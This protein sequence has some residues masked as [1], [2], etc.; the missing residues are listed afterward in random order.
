[1]STSTFAKAKAAFIDRDG[2]INE[3]RNYV[4]RIEE[5]VLLPGVFQGLT[6]LRNAGYLLIV[7][8]NQ[9]GIARGYYDK[10]AMENIHDHLRSLLAQKGVV[11]DAI[12]FCPHHP[13]GNV[14]TL[15][16]ECECRKP[17]PGM[18]F[19]A[20]KDFDLD[21]TASILIGDKISDVQA[22]R[23]AGVGRTVIVKSGHNLEPSA[24]LEADVIAADLFAAARL[25]TSA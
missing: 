1:M 11:L 18:L 14:E 3:E 13:Q 20:A 8:T 2:V 10:R 23:R 16:I 12:Y 9:A 25:M 21:L 17:Q 19:Q 22:G 4:H 24:C 15:A 6:L 7:V 5:F